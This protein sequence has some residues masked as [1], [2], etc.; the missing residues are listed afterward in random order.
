MAVDIETIG[1]AVDSKGVVKGTRDLDTF[2]KSANK[3]SK[4]ADNFG[5]SST[6]ASKGAD[7]VSKSTSSSIGMLKGLAAAYVSLNSARALLGAIDNYTKY[8]AQLKLATRSQAEYN[9]ALADVS[10]IANT[11]Q[12]SISSIA[13]LYARLNNAVR[14]L[15][16]TQDQVARVTE[17]VGLALKVSGATAQESA[18]AM[19][20]LS[21][22]FG[23]G[24]LRGE[25]FNAVNEAAPALMRALAESIG[26]PI[27][28]LRNMASEG[29]IT[30]QVLILNY[31]RYSVTKRNK[32]IH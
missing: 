2:G 19:L 13:T 5:K 31:W 28:A 18:S 24:V 16:A 26:V 1:I 17:N 8:N 32:S 7:D 6:K 10:R 30:A 23:S 27:G 21:Q 15:G 29:E 22:A 4:E 25:E 14:E 11:A 20:Q 3:A 9:T 12:A